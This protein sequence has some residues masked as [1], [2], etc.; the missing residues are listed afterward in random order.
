MIEPAAASGGAP[1]P[2]PAPARVLTNPYV[3]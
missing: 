3:A 2:R 1:R